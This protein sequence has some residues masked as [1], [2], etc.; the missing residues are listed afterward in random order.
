MSRATFDLYLNQWTLRL[1][2][3]LCGLDVYGALQLVCAC[4]AFVEYQRT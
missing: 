4:S 1:R 2:G 3:G